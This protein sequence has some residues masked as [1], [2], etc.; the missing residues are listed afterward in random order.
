[1]RWRD[2]ADSSR[3]MDSA[4]NKSYMG[5]REN[6]AKPEEWLEDFRNPMKN[7]SERSGEEDA[8][9]NRNMNRRMRETDSNK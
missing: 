5:S 1:M 2:E 7:P 4:K 8:D 3:L 9:L 6:T